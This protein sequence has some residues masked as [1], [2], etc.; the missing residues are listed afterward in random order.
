MGMRERITNAQEEKK[1]L[2]P[3]DKHFIKKLY[4]DF[5]KTS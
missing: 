1:K 4:K 2:L 5:M 3:M